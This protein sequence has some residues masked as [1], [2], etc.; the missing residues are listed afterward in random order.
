M[1]AAADVFK[2][3]YNRLSRSVGE[4]DFDS[5]RHHS[6][7]VMDILVG[8][9][10]FK[11]LFNDV[12]LMFSLIK[13]FKTGAYRD[14]S[15]ATIGAILFGIAYLVA[16]I[17]LI[18]DFIPVIGM[19]DDLAIFRVAIAFIQD[20]LA[21]YRRWKEEMTNPVVEEAEYEAVETA[22]DKIDVQ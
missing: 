11:A 14:V 1:R 9:P 13:D 3:V 15:W 2:R 4:F 19:L 18:P 21:L 10:S 17:D 5:F 7:K 6:G 22:P 16:P 12:K 8:V 20:D